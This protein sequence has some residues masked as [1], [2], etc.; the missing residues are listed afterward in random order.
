MNKHSVIVLAIITTWSFFL[1]SCNNKMDKKELL[2]F[3]SIKVNRIEHLLGDTAKPYC[4]LIIN[5]MY[6]SA[7]NNAVLKDTMTHYILELCLGDDYTNQTPQIEV[8]NYVTHYI[9]QYRQELEPTF[10]QESDKSVQEWYNYYRCIKGKA[11]MCNANVLTYRLDLNEY[12]GG[13]HNMY[14]TTYENYDLIRMKKLKTD[15]LFKPNYQNELTFDIIT[16]LMKDKEVTTKEAL[17]EKGYGTTGTIYPTEN[18]LLDKDGITFFYNVYE[19]APYSN[20]TTAIRIPYSKLKNI[21]NTE[22][23]TRLGLI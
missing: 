21:I 13:A 12:T 1:F 23:F 22:V 2:T 14:S 4:N 16:Q 8:Q 5:I 19:I 20:G 7:S 9:T 18:F 15:D 10:K 3:D 6:P 11:S 17:A